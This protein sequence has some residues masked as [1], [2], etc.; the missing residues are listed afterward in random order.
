MHVRLNPQ[1][2]KARKVPL[3][4]R[5]FGPYFRVGSQGEL[6]GVRVTAGPHRMPP[7]GEADWEVTYV[8]DGDYSALQPDVVFEVVEGGRVIGRGTV[9]EVA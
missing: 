4:P 8:F 3:S 5:G 9:I 6:L 2:L 7:T 1:Y